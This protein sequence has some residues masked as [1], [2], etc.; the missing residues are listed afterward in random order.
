MVTTDTGRILQMQLEVQSRI[1]SHLF[2]FKA[3]PLWQNQEYKNQ[4][5]IQR[6][7]LN[8]IGREQKWAK[9]GT[10]HTSLKVLFICRCRL[11]STETL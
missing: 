11:A 5:Q 8:N 10:C 3:S 4:W 7:E 9:D 1:V 2:I 6:T